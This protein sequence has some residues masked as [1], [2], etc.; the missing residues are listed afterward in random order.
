MSWKVTYPLHEPLLTRKRTV[1]P[2]E[3][4][5]GII[6]FECSLPTDEPALTRIQD[7]LPFSTTISKN[8][9][10]AAAFIDHAGHLAQEYGSVSEYYLAPIQYGRLATDLCIGL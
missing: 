5:V 10:L 9:A 4:Q 1:I 3:R 8:L 7:P 2:P 6:T